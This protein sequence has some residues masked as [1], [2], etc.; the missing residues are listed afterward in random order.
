MSGRT[1]GDLGIKRVLVYLAGIVILALGLT[2]NTKTGLGAGTIL[3]PAFTVSQIFR[4][5][6]GNVTLVL[7]L[8]MMAVEL[9]LDRRDAVKILL[10]FPFS[11]IFTRIMN[12]FGDVIPYK[13]SMLPL[14]IAVAVLAACLTGLGIFLTVNMKLIPN[15]ADGF[16]KV[17]SEK[18][19]LELGRT[20]IM[21]DVSCVILALLIGLTKGRPLAGVGIGTLLCMVLVGPA[22]SFFSM[23]FKDKL[24]PVDQ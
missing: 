24:P 1:G 23:H 14:N 21:I 17:I 20:K 10:Q 18:S 13:S 7:Y 3:S 16:V 11:L 22:V 2:L 8:L 5:N 9:I 4:L 6:F 19:G 15:P 12:F